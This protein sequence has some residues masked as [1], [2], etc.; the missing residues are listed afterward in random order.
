ME[1]A[2]RDRCG[3]RDRGRQRVKDGR[4][5]R[6]KNRDGKDHRGKKANRHHLSALIFCVPEEKQIHT[7]I[8]THVKMHL[9]L[10]WLIIYTT[11]SITQCLKEAE[12]HIQSTCCSIKGNMVGHRLHY[13]HSLGICRTSFIFRKTEDDAGKKRLY[14]L[15]WMRLSHWKLDL[16]LKWLIW[17][18]GGKLNKYQ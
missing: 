9:W 7:H 11:N 3:E 10:T 15:L 17:L 12:H 16:A 5:N 6:S 1:G 4:T 18:N 2:Q 8:H 13:S 14:I